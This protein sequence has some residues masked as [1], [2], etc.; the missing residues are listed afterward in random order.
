[1]SQQDGNYSIRPIDNVMGNDLYAHDS[2]HH[3]GTMNN[4]SINN[5]T[6]NNTTMNNNNQSMVTL[7]P[8]HDN[9]NHSSNHRQ[10]VARLLPI[11][12]QCGGKN[13]LSNKQRPMSAGG[14]GDDNKFDLLLG[15]GK[16]RQHQTDSLFPIKPNPPNPPNPASSSLEAQ[17]FF[18][19]PTLTKFSSNVGHGTS[20]LGLTGHRGL[21][22][23]GSPI[24]RNHNPLIS[25]PHIINTAIAPQPQYGIFGVGGNVSGI[26]PGGN[27]DQQGIVGSIDDAGINCSKIQQADTVPIGLATKKQRTNAPQRK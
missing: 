26:G 10:P 22:I 11:P 23:P 1:M 13:D 5:T 9:T 24:P 14:A 17:L 27:G 6:I 15:K 4:S 25:T 12:V 3:D 21:P 8:Q 19:T 7:T 20:R 2:T 16:G 18:H